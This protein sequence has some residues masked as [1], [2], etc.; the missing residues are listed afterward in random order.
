[1]L[2][3]SVAAIGVLL[4]A[5]TW[6]PA[7]KIKVWHHGATTHY[8]KAQLKGA[9][10]TS[11][12]TLRL[13]RRLKPLVALDATHV[14]DVVEDRQ[15]NLIAATGDE[16]KIFRITPEG[17]V[18]LVFDSE[19]SQVL[20]LAS[21][22]DGTIYA[23]TGPSGHIICISPEGAARVLCAT[24]ESYVWSLAVDKNNDSI[25][26]GTGPKGK[27][28]RVTTQGKAEVFYATR[29]EH[30]LSLAIAPDG[31]LY[32]G[33]DKNGL[34]YR[35]DSR[36]KGFVLYHA[37]QAE[38][39]SL[40]LS[41]GGLYA[42]TS[43]PRRRSASLNSANAH[44][45][46]ANSPAMLVST[47]KSASRTGSGSGRV[48]ASTSTGSGSHDKDDESS[49]RSS[50]PPPRSGDN[51]V[52]WIGEDGNAREVFREKALILSLLRQEGRVFIG[53]G[54]EGQL[55]EV[56]EATKEHSEVA[57]LDNGQ[58]HCMYRRRDGSIILGTGDPGKLYVLED[59]YAATGTVTSEVLDARLISKW[60]ALRWK[61]VTPPGTRLTVAV[62]SGNLAEPDETWSD[63]SAELADSEQ[64]T[65]AAPPAR[66]LQ[67][68]ITLHSDDSHVTPALKSIALRYSTLN[69]AP[70]ITAI[71][72]PDLSASNS[73]SAKKLHF[74]WTATDPN[75][76][77]L[78]YTLLVKKDSWKN[79]IQI[80]ENL[81]KKEFEWDTTATPSG[82]Y[83]LKVVA[84]DRKDNPP[85]QALS[86]ER[87]SDPFTI[88]HEPPAVV[89]KVA[90]M[91]GDQAVIE[92]TGT[93]AHVRLTS[94][95]FSVNGKKWINVFP[96][97]G[98]FDSKT[99]TFRFKTDSLKPGTY[100]VVLRIRDAAG[101]TGSG[102]AVFTVQ[103]RDAGR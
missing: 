84:S 26:A 34:V 95:S 69:Q 29:Q 74:K 81:E 6:S 21:G 60:G 31:R 35:F 3:S 48:P 65:A 62:R 17:K 82:T 78:T 80:E 46:L 18:S 72:V 57:R 64:A 32:A 25:Y 41:T 77:E 96:T 61:G 16:G 5:A 55:F 90:G 98:L 68:R 22:T 19:D 39:R 58:I 92:A 70:E 28:Y 12:G 11:E 49:E 36:G 99:E 13:S 97:D 30:I 83:Q 42:G 9:V 66:F 89:L 79:W 1:M 10:V 4:L 45:S 103:Q 71:D 63:W 24:P 56:D 93:D 91:E 33:T 51:S 85:E 86:C 40:L 76:D 53:T 101:N 20:C 100:V 94:A 67:Y 52:Y 75:D 8:E 38:V 88:A 43:S 23:G 7:G 59:Q 14:W 2:R 50:P 73:D 87:I 44:S 27:I 54:M 102:D 15:G 37:P 47:P